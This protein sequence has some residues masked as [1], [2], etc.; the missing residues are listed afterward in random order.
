[1]RNVEEKEI[2]KELEEI[3]EMTK[4][5]SSID[6]AVGMYNDG[7]KA[8]FDRIFPDVEEMA[9]VRHNVK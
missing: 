5:Q 1:M 9:I 3:G 7:V 8:L 6:E 4:G 2:K